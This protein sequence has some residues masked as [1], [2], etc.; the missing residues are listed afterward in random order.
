MRTYFCIKEASMKKKN[1]K[2]YPKKIKEFRYHNVYVIAKNGKF[3]KIRHPTYSF[4]LIGNVLVY[5][6]ITHSKIVNGVHTIELRK[7]PNPKDKRKAYRSKGIQQ[8]TK[9]RFGRTNK[10]WTIDP[11]D[12]LE[13]RE[14]NKNDDS[15]DR[16]NPTYEHGES[17][18][19]KSS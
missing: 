9:D 12:D 3:K 2:Y 10:K 7:N 18:H 11:L 4:L 15:A 16:T 17:S 13:I 14:Q 8:D 5:V 19:L 1:N 6:T